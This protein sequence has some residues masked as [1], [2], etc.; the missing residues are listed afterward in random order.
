MVTGLCPAESR[1]MVV[2]LQRSLGL[3]GRSVDVAALVGA[4]LNKACGRGCERWCLCL[5]VCVTVASLCGLPVM[6]VP[7]LMQQFREDCV[8]AFSQLDSERSVSE[9]VLELDL[10]LRTLA[11]AHAHITSR[12]GIPVKRPLGCNFLPPAYRIPNR[13]HRG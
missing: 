13:R 6:R 5:C 9:V 8:Q 11:G 10:F 1:A 3:L 12:F 2:T 7:R 4:Q